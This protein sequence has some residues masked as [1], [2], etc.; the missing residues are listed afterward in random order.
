MIYFTIKEQIMLTQFQNPRI[1][2]FTHIFIVLNAPLANVWVIVLASKYT[3]K[4]IT[5]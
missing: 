3:V 4:K 5:M 1:H 2:I